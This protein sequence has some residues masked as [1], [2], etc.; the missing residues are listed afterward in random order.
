MKEL[1]VS[2]YREELV[3]YL[4]TVGVASGLAHCTVI[5]SGTPRSVASH[6]GVFCLPMSHER[7]TRLR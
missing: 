4:R 2:V 7:D 1:N 5:H 6:L 3:I